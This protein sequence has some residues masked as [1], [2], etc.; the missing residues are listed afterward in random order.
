MSGT[1][2][3]RRHP[4]TGMASFL[5][6]ACALAGCG[7]GDDDDGNPTGSAA[8]AGAYR[9]ALE[10]IIV[11][12]NEIEMDVQET[13]VGSSGQATAANLAAAFERLRP[14]LRER[15]EAFDQI[16]PPAAWTGL[17]GQIRELMSLRLEAFDALLEGFVS[18]D[19]SLYATAEQR[20]RQANDLIV[21]IN[22]QLMEMDLSL[23]PAS[24]ATV[25]GKPA[26]SRV[27][28]RF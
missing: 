17:H 13:A 22:E 12:V 8:S 11:A 24:D 7:D 5:V 1:T 2:G 15:L 9:K 23:A 10:P 20:L 27:L 26:R 28:D 25:T 19:L 21:E 14:R 16:D 18:A 6:L 3:H 4:T